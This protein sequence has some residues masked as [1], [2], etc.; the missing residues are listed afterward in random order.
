MKA[1]IKIN[2]RCTVLGNFTEKKQLY[3]S[4]AWG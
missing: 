1:H 2:D 4:A 3:D